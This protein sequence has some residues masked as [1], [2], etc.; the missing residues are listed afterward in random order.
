[1]VGKITSGNS[2]YGVLAYNTIKV[3]QGQGK[4]I[5]SKNTLVTD[6]TDHK[7]FFPLLLKS[8][9]TNL[10]AN[11]RTKSPIFHVSLNPDPRDIISEKSLA[12][13][14]QECME[15]MGYGEQPY[16]VYE[17]N[18]IDRKHIH[19][20]S[21][22]V[23]AAGKKI[24]HDFEARKSVTI[25][26]DIETKYGLHPAIKG[27]SQSD[28]QTLTKVDYS[29][30]NVKQ[31]LSSS[32]RALKSKYNF[33]SV[34]EFN[35]LLN[36]YNV[37]VEHLRG[38]IDGRTYEGIIYGAVNDAAEPIGIPIKSSRIGQDVGIKA[39]QKK[40]DK[41]KEQLKNNP[42]IADKT[43]NAVRIAMQTAKSED[44][45]K[46]LL[47]AEN[48]DVIFRRNADGRLYGATFIDHNTHTVYN[49]SRLG[50]EFSANKFH[51][52]FNLPQHESA[53]VIKQTEQPAT[54]QTDAIPDIATADDPV[55]LTDPKITEQQPFS[56]YPYDNYEYNSDSNM[57]ETTLDTFDIFS[58]ALEIAELPPEEREQ[59][60]RI[61]KKKKKR[62]KW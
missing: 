53:E 60:F 61:Q 3:E 25:L 11:K 21:V 23:D 30:G 28:Y 9:E 59:Q 12:D 45:F 44:E 6:K 18:D 42:T 52:L 54:S 2:L 43:R 51:E 16:I 47:K 8:F 50:K 57:L 55:K 40:F 15:R 1:M 33:A 49:G 5:F 46:Q 29:K 58:T 41:A 19:I 26:Q 22:R 27:V 4:V 13:I 48:I 10:N 56:T 35:S 37:R 34:T 36:T 32:V 17:H 24:E 31:Q 62:F 20:V 14:A 38:E 39:L 7:L